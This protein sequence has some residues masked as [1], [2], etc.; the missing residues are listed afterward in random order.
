MMRVMLPLRA[1]SP[2]AAALA[3]VA[4]AACAGVSPRPEL[5]R[6][7][8]LPDRQRTAAEQQRL[9]AI[10][11]QAVEAVVTRRYEE[12]ERHANAALGLDSRSGR[13]R[14]VLGMALLQRAKARDPVD[15][16]LANAGEREIVLAQQCAP[17]DAFVGWLHAVFLAESGHVSAAADAAEAALGR[18]AAATD[19]ERAA[20]SGIAGTYRYELGEERAALAHLQAYAAL[21][22]DDVAATFRIGACLLRIADVTVGPTGLL[23]AQRSAEAAARAFARCA[24]KAPGDEDAALAVASAQVRAAEL[25]K[26]RGERAAQG[27]LLLGAQQQLRRVAAAFPRSAEARFRIGVVEE[28]RLAP[29]AARAAYAEALAIDGAHLGA[30]LNSA[31]LAAASNDAPAA[32]DFARRA[33]AVDDLAR[34][35][36]AAERRRLVEFVATRP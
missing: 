12:A 19:D 9:D 18:A 22:P 10:V 17:G 20:L 15:L 14:A 8:S 3:S 28:L 36:S 7:D 29:D 2:L 23:D 1:R 6:A 13:A 5:A 27:E 25:A 33:L 30:L 16:F 4:L 21:R 34:E 24:E 31:S 32:V 11:A 35:L 26:E